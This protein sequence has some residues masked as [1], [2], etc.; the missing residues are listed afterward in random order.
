MRDE[1]SKAKLVATNDQLVA[2]L[3]EWYNDP[4]AKEE[5]VALVRYC[6]EEAQNDDDPRMQMMANFALAGMMAVAATLE[7]ET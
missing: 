4:E 5:R 6:E 2:T 3:A 7:T 1:K